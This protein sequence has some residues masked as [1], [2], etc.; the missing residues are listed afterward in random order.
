MLLEGKMKRKTAKEILAE[1]FR[2]LAEIK[3]IDKITVQDITKNCEYS[4]ATFYRQFRDKYDLIA[5]DY[6]LDVEKILGRAKGDY[7]SW[8][9]VL[10][11]AAD[12]FCKQKGYIANLLLHT[13]G[14]DSFVRN[15]TEIH[16]ENLKKC[17]LKS[18]GTDRLDEKLDMYIRLYCQGTVALT[19]EWI[20]G[21][22]NVEMEELVEIYEK[23]L[24]EPL[25]CY[26]CA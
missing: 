14:Y 18:A 13:N 19:G 10:R 2:E 17:I 6:S 16:Y 5:W 23:A 22:Y 9:R 24:P 26:L 20:L 8:M 1:S 21:K 3:P 12:F 11:E 7:E 15:M 4:S 25:K